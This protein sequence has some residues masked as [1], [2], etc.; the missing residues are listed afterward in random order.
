MLQHHYLLPLRRNYLPEKVHQQNTLGDPP[1]QRRPPVATRGSSP[2]TTLTDGASDTTC[3]GPT[4]S[5]DSMFDITGRDSLVSVH[6]SILE[7]LSISGICEREEEPRVSVPPNRPRMVDS[8]TSPMSSPSD[9]T[10]RR[11]GQEVR[12]RQH[13]VE[14]DWC[15]RWQHRK[16]GT[17][18]TQTAYREAMRLGEVTYVC[19]PC[20][21]AEAMDNEMPVLE[22]TATV[23]QVDD[24]DAGDDHPI[25]LLEESVPSDESETLFEGSTTDAT[26]R[27]VDYISR[28]WVH[29]GSFEPSDWSVFRQDSVPTTTLKVTTTA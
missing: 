5:D 10:S 6:S 7:N 3:S 11:C 18:I 22:I 1:T 4:L 9:N 27:L 20:I 19:R 15:N 16:C 21:D 2:S 24:D 26:R 28:Q 13:A 17:G 14:C 12:P 25:P 29:S 8:Q 23:P